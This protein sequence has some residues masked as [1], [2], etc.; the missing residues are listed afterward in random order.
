MVIISPFSLDLFSF[1]SSIYIAFQAFLFI[2]LLSFSGFAF[3]PHPKKLSY[4]LT[5][6]RAVEGMFIFATFSWFSWKNGFNLFISGWI[7]WFLVIILLLIRFS[8]N[9]KSV[10]SFKRSVVSFFIFFKKP[11]LIYFLMAFFASLLWTPFKTPLST[12]IMTLG[13]NDIFSWALLANHL[14]NNSNLSLITGGDALIRMINDCFG[15]YTIV[16]LPSLIGS[17]PLENIVMIVIAQCALLGCLM[18]ALLESF[19][20][21]KIT[22]SFC[23]IFLFLSNPLWV[24]INH[25]VFVS[26]IISTVGLFYTLLVIS[27][28][29]NIDEESKIRFFTTLS[30]V[31]FM[32]ISF[33]LLMYPALAVMHSL[34]ILFFLVVSFLIKGSLKSDK[35]T[36]VFK[37]QL[38]ATISYAIGLICATLVF[39][40][41]AIYTFNRSFEVIKLKAGWPLPLLDALTLLGFSNPYQGFY[42]TFFS[43]PF[44]YVLVILIVLTLGWLNKEENKDFVSY[45]WH[46]KRITQWAGYISYILVLVSYLLVYQILGK[47]YQQWKFASYYPLTFSI[48][49]LGILSKVLISK[50]TYLKVKFHKNKKIKFTP[51]FAL[52]GIFACLIFAN[53]YNAAKGS[54][55]VLSQDIKQLTNINK[56]SSIDMVYIDLTPYTET[57]AA[58]NYINQKKIVP[59]SRSYI[60]GNQIKFDQ[61]TQKSPLITNKLGCTNISGVEWNELIDNKVILIN[62]LPDPNLH[63][64]NKVS[65]SNYNKCIY[66]SRDLIELVEGFSPSEKWGT[67]SAAISA[68]VRIYYKRVDLDNKK[69]ITI[70]FKLSAFIAP[71][72]INSQSITAKFNNFNKTWNFNSVGPHMIEIVIPKEFL[73]EGEFFDISFFFQNATRPKDIDDKTMDSRQLAIGFLDAEIF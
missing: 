2:F 52:V 31:F 36:S 21:T 5:F 6:E 33:F 25:S 54:M 66:S 61:V 30:S 59:I 34:V 4:P 73:N 28:N 3:L 43:S 64:E 47:S 9:F 20:E 38:L 71:P 46:F 10:E 41:L 58:L 24:Y 12:D 63:L 53:F 68:V 70:K 62:K 49:I 45:E 32:S 26:H 35:L 1:L 11:F 27:Q 22:T 72:K 7:F 13:N 15:I 67:W 65:F 8:S 69:D 19:F 29:I 18:Y 16:G 37:I 55:Q 14:F 39:Y 48:F 60:P 23:I 17:L 40:D 56:I 42:D 57:M 44:G 50:L 51:N